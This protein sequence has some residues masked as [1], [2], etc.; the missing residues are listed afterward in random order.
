MP[1]RSSCG[2]VLGVRAGRRASRSR[3][4]GR[5][6][7]RPGRRDTGCAEVDPCRG[8]RSW[9]PVPS[10]P[11]ARPRGRRL[12]GEAEA[13]WGVRRS[14]P[15]KTPATSGLCSSSA[16]AHGSRIGREAVEDAGV[17]VVGPDAEA[18]LASWDQHLLLCGEG[19][20]RPSGARACSVAELARRDRCAT[21]GVS[22]HDDPRAERSSTGQVRLVD[23]PDPRHGAGF[24]ADASEAREWRTVSQAATPIAA[25]AR[26][27]SSGRRSKRI[28][29]KVLGGRD[30]GREARC[31]GDHRCV[32]G[33][34]RERRRTRA[35]KRRAELRVGGDAADDRDAARRR[36]PRSA[37]RARGRSR[38]GSSRRG[39][40]GAPRAPP[41]SGRA[42][43][44]GARS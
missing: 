26:T 17:A 4:R 8:A 1:C 39:R 15:G 30:G 35:G 25:R 23:E 32:V 2:R 11:A 43:R 6:P 16:I 10:N 38:A 34:E 28:E 37:R 13:N 27:A 20:R 29:R 40:R 24:A 31:G 18:V 21:D 19:L 5:C 44:R 22:Q 42:P 12:R 9:R 36:P 33:A 3:R 7:A 41:G 14:G